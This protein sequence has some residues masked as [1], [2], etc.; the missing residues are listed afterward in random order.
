MYNINK[1]S[2]IAVLLFLLTI[3]NITVLSGQEPRDHTEPRE[4][5]KYKCKGLFAPD[6]TAQSRFNQK[7]D[8]VLNTVFRPDQEFVADSLIKVF[9]DS[10]SFGIFKDNYVVLGTE[11]F[12]NPDRNNSDAKF[13]ISVS[14]RLTNSVLPFRTYLFLTYTQL[15]FWDVFKESFPFRDINFNPTIG[16]GKPLV[17]KNRY[18]G[19]IAF[20]LEHESNGKDGDASRSW[21]KVSFFGQFRFNSHW[22]YFSKVWVPI[23]DG[24]NNRNIVRYRGWAT[25]ALSYNQ[26]EKFNTSL[27]VNKR[28]GG[29]FNAN[30]TINFAYRL[31]HDENQ[32]LFFE[33]Y[34]G[35]GEGLLDYNQFHQRFRLGFVIKPN[36]TRFIY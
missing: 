2:K 7:A 1:T 26:K 5:K 23:V 11:L 28:G 21:N 4:Y 19:E 36:F 10:P 17:Y 20:Q 22:S 12:R 15:A 33:F 6:S 24:E 27:I 8:Q 14:Q 9:D 13:Q 3:T 25:S 31:F 34:N 29:F 32:Y 30:V 16:L 35:Y 18:L